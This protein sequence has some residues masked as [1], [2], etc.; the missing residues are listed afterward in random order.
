MGREFGSETKSIRVVKRSIAVLQTINRTES[1]TL[2]QITE[3]VG[4]TYATTTRIVRTLMEEGLVEQE[5]S[6]KRYRP[7]ALVHTLSCGFQNHD[8]LVS[9]SRRHI[10]ELT[11]QTNWPA[12]I[13]TRVGRSM[14]TRDSTSPL[15]SWTFSNYYPG[16]HVPL[17][18]SASG[19]IYFAHCSAA[20]QSDIL[21]QYTSA[22]KG[23]DSVMLKKFRDSEAIAKVVS[24]G[25]AAAE[26]TG[27]SAN[28]GKTSS[29][30]VPLFEG[31]TL[32]GSL[33]LVFF[34]SAISI[35][36]AIDLFLDPLQRTSAAI[37]Q[38]LEVH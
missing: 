30:A 28:P 17:L 5:P 8:R 7:T 9:A 6:R 19:C 27:F 20:E 11:R 22:H 15:T 35:P 14:V 10:V 16:W 37:R 32:V 13:S 38:D 3:R 29:I 24:A 1:A 18:S 36:K 33:A 2:T 26:R 21:K 12:S 34:A 23:P 31:E 4:L 25:Y